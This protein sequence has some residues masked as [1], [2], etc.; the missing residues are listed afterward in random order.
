MSLILHKIVSAVRVETHATSAVVK[1]EK[2]AVD[3]TSSSLKVREIVN[4]NGSMTINGRPTKLVARELSMGYTHALKDVYKIEN[5]PRSLELRSIEDV[6][7]SPS[8]DVGENIRFTEN[9]FT[10]ALNKKLEREGKKVMNSTD[11]ADEIT[12]SVVE[13]NPA[14]K[15]IF[16]NL[17]G[18]TVR[19]VG[20]TILKIGLGI[21]AVCLIVNEHRNR[22]TGCYLYFY[23]K[24]Q[25]KR[26]IIPQ[27]TCKKIDCKKDCVNCTADLMKKYL[28]NDMMVD[29]CADFKGGAGCSQCPSDTY[30]KTDITDDS[31]LVKDDVDNVSF[32]RCQRPNFFEALT[33]I[34]G[35]ISEELID[36]V[37][38]SLNAVSWIVRKLPIILLF[39]FIGFIIIIL[40]SIF[41][42]FK[43][44]SNSYTL[45]TES[46]DNS[47]TDDSSLID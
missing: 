38:K 34:F 23:Y 12:P 4:F 13:R 5:V 8:F 17:S 46:T 24:N 31:T 3:A 35:G 22:L 39:A 20:G 16:N 33:D 29:N 30:T 27:C 26:C 18:K 11:L 21:A 1:L 10:P 47:I 9:D 6:K 45:L 15:N 32:V 43:S 19:T 37:D 42:K 2:Y 28:P 36:I 41:G 44:N 7:L 40:I 25:L 14:L